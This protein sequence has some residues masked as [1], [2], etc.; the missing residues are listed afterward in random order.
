MDRFLD[1]VWRLLGEFAGGPGPK[2][3]NLVRF[4]LPAIFLA[5]LWAIAWSR[6]RR[7]DLPREKLLVWGFGLAFFREL[8]MF[9]HFA[10]GMIVP[11]EQEL[12]HSVTEP[13]EHALTMAAIVVVAGAFLRYIL[14]DARTSRRYLQIGL[15][16]TT[17]CFL[18]AFV[19]WGPYAR[20]NL[21]VK[22][23]ETWYGAGVHATTAGLIIIAILLLARKR[24][25]LRNVVSV[26]LLFFF[27]DEFLR[28][29]GFATG[30]VHSNVLCPL[31]N[32]FHIWAM[33]I[34]G[35]VYIREQGVEK[36][37]AE[38]ELKAYKDH[39]EEL[40]QERTDELEAQTNI[41]AT[42]SRSLELDRILNAALEQVLDVLE[43]DLGI[44]FL[45]DPDGKTMSLKAY[46]GVPD[47]F[48][49]AAQPIRLDQCISGRAV[50][51]KQPVIL[52]ASDPAVR[53]SPAFVTQD[54]MQTLVSTPLVS[55]GRAVG[56]MTLGTRRPDGMPPA[57]LE[58]L[59]AVGQQIGMA[60]DNA[61]LYQE[62]ERWAEELALLHE[63]SLF[64]NST[65]DPATIHRQMTE[66]AARLLGCPVSCFLQWDQERQE[67]IGAF[68]YGSSRIDIS[69]VR[70]RLPECGLLADLTGQ[71]RSVPI[72]DVL[73]GAPVSPLWQERFAARSI[74]GVPVWGASRPL[75]FLFLIERHAPRRWRR[76]EIELV[77]SF[78]NRAA[79]ALENAYLHKQL[80]WAAALEERQ[81]I[82]AEMHDGLAQTLSYL[83]H[84]FDQVTE[85]VEQERLEEVTAEYQQIRHAI[86]QASH[87]VRR[88]I[89]SLQESP[90]PRRS[91]QAWLREAVDAFMAQED[92]QVELVIRQQEPVFAPAD[93]LEQILR[94]VQEALLNAHRHAQ[95]ANITIVLER[96]AD[97]VQMVIQD[98]GRGFDP[99]VPPTMRGEHF[100]LSIMRAR[101]AR[102]GGQLHIDS[103]P[104]R[105]TRVVL[106]WSPSD[107]PS[108]THAEQIESVIEQSTTRLTSAAS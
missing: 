84:R 96:Q 105:G 8:L 4:G 58:L 35:Y 13:V 86:D 42:L 63:V 90:R 33:P 104:E 74:L 6:Q 16:A 27:M 77:E 23:N 21:Q 7:Q 22:F 36:Q 32:S 50:T 3:N 10:V 55:K 26:A 1:F 56:A 71:R 51:G 53:R 78:V 2:E 69:S 28:L 59:T 31:A 95:A 99:D 47:E 15:S 98:D 52:D 70:V 9:V 80:E 25:W 93:H 46:R 38:D 29:L 65:L 17:I 34:L 61:H 85:L 72:S 75:G 48:V 67:A 12:G 39:L 73:A 20:A 5:A 88:S 54:G 18:I 11:M 101:A 24:G 83:G 106:T 14:N 92:R 107:R 79:V 41:A 94:V 97:K 100:G 76:Q 89:A 57:K 62:T 37:Q 19:G 49:A 40:I 45:T 60:V 43:M 87:D 81:R 82:A 103:T 44:I 91:L 68:C 64:L 30:Q 66:Q 102:I 108:R